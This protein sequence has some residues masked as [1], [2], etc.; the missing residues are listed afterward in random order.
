MLLE[1]NLW[2]HED[3]R[4]LHLANDA[5]EPKL[6]PIADGSVS[7]GRRE[8]GREAPEQSGPHKHGKFDSPSYSSVCRAPAF[9]GAGA[10]WRGS[11]SPGC[12]SPDR[13]SHC[14]WS[15]EPTGSIA[16]TPSGRTF[17]YLHLPDDPRQLV[18]LREN[19]PDE[20][21]DKLLAK[22][23]QFESVSSNA[24]AS[25][26][27]GASRGKA[28]PYVLILLRAGRRELTLCEH[29]ASEASIVR[30]MFS[31]DSQ[32]VFFGSDRHGKPAIYRVHVE[33][34]VEETAEPA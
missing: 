21:T 20:N 10:L 4:T 8:V 15:R 28:S 22:T 6:A 16:W 30:P 18:T 3:A 24:D 13:K 12:S 31:P 26:F 9:A 11:V 32:S 5:A 1:A 7:G 25:V 34:F 29:K 27:A 33:K 23:S 14:D 17:L 2:D 19:T